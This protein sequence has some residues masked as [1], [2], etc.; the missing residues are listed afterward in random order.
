MCVFITRR[1]K[2]IFRVMLCACV[3]TKITVTVLIQKL[4]CVSLPAGS[5]TLH[6]FI[7]ACLNPCIL[8]GELHT[9]KQTCKDCV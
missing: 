4:W 2:T 8:T 6:C 9:E 7:R 1:N 5:Y 3:Y